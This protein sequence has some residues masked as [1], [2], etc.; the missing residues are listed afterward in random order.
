MQTL[1]AALIALAVN[2]P[3]RGADFVLVDEACQ[4][5]GRTADGKSTVFP[6]STGSAACWFTG[7]AVT[8]RW[9][10]PPAQFPDVIDQ[11]GVL[12]F[13][14]K[15]MVVVVDWK[16]LRFALTDQ[17]VA[18]SPLGVISKQCSGTVVDR[19]KK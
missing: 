2:A 14:N 15:R 4:V 13:L 1:A 10:D 5:T 12:A 6:G 17:T 7:A 9:Q 19:R 8:C 3:E 18:D 16:K 11:A